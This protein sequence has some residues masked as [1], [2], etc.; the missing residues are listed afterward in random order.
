MVA[1]ATSPRSIRRRRSLCSRFGS[2]RAAELALRRTACSQ[3]QRRRLTSR[4][5]HRLSKRRQA[6]RTAQPL[7]RCK[8]PG[9]RM[10]SRG[11]SLL[12]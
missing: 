8:T 11:A 5:R 6:W 9:T 12:R 10:Q 4:L 2:T 3:A 1:A 7:V